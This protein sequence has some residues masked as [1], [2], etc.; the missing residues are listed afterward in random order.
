MP[1]ATDGFGYAN[2]AIRGRKL[3]PI[4]EEQVDPALAL[5]PD[6]VSIHA[7]AND[8]LR[9]RVDLDDLAAAYDEGSV[10]S[11]PPAPTS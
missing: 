8:V 4:L 2:L 7:G 3:R 6:L 5:A 10:A 1:P 11:P 9:P